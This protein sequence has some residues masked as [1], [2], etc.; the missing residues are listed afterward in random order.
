MSE[1][2][3]GIV[4]YF[5]HQ[6]IE[7][8]FGEWSH[9]DATSATCNG[10]STR[11]RNHQSSSKRVN[12]FWVKL[13]RVSQSGTVSHCLTVVKEKLW[14]RELVLTGVFGVEDKLMLKRRFFDEVLRVVFSFWVEVV[15]CRRWVRIKW[16]GSDDEIDE[17]IV[18]WANILF[19]RG[20]SF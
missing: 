15:S 17:A 19:E 2:C 10:R 11:K 6:P 16:S 4:Q 20:N 9:D 7:I 5:K 18:I 1:A 13:F 3:V 8:N 14:W 12:L